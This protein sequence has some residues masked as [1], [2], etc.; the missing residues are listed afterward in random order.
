MSTVA[1][2]EAAIAL[3]ERL[4]EIESLLILQKYDIQGTIATERRAITR[5]IE[6]AAGVGV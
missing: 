3:N 6:L 1:E 2:A 5:R 4:E